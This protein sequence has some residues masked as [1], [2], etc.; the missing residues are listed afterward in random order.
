MKDQLLKKLGEIAERIKQAPDRM[1]L[2]RIA[3][4]LEEIEQTVKSEMESPL[5]SDNE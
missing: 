4:E 3:L 5:R 1:E 2:V